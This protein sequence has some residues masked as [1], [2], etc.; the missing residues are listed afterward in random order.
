MGSLSLIFLLEGEG[1]TYTGT[2]YFFYDLLGD[3]ILGWCDLFTELED[4]FYFLSLLDARFSK[5]F[6]SFSSILAI[7]LGTVGSRFG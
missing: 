2:Y 1:F 6:T 7:N 4:S 3:N 5:E